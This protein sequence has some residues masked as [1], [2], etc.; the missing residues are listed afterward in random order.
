MY[1]NRYLIQMMKNER[2]RTMR[3]ERSSTAFVLVCNRLKAW[4]EH[5]HESLIFVDRKSNTSK[6]KKNEKRENEAQGGKCRNKKNVTSLRN[7]DWAT[8]CTI[9]RWLLFFPYVVWVC[10]CVLLLLSSWIPHISCFYRMKLVR[11]RRQR[12]V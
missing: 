11:K 12:I 8:W 5:K 4:D 2:Q 1:M 9:E 10:E 6:K 3:K 7:F